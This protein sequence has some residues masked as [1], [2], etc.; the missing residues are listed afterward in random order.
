MGIPGL[1]PGIARP[2][3]YSATLW[4]DDGAGLA[5]EEGFAL[6]ESIWTFS[7]TERVCAVSP[8]IETHGC[9]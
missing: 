3:G 5:D 7:V 9:S 6:F 2:L 4:K 1:A 8:L